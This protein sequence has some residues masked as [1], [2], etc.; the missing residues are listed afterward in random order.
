MEKVKVKVL[1]GFRLTVP[2]EARRRLPIKV[3]DELE[4]AVEG[5]RIIYKVK[6]LPEDPVFAMLGLASGRL[7]KLSGVEEAVVGEVEEKLERGSR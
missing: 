1:S 4:F 2:E 6:G 7:R 3:G 5:N